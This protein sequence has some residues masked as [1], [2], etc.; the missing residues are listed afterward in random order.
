ME[1]SPARPACVAPKRPLDVVFKDGF[2]LSQDRNDLKDLALASLS[3]ALKAYF[4]SYH[5]A[6]MVRD[7]FQEGGGGANADSSYSPRYFEDCAE[8]ILHFH[9]F[10][11]LSLKEVLRSKHQLLAADASRLSV[12]LDKLLAN[13]AVSAEEMVRLSSP[14]F[15]DT[16]TR[17]CDLIRAGRLDQATLS[18]IPDAGELLKQLNNLRN[19]LWHRGTFIL[20]YQAFDELIGGSVLP[21]VKKLVSLQH[22]GH[23]WGYP[24]LHCG[25]D[26]AEEIIA[27]MAGGRRLRKVA[28]LKELGRA[29]FENPAPFE[30]GESWT[31]E[32]RRRAT[33]AAKSEADGEGVAEIRACPVCGVESLV[34]YESIEAEGEES[35][36]GEAELVVRSTFA[37]RCM[38][39]T[40]SI[41]TAVDNASVWGLRIDD[42]WRHEAY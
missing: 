14:E 20:R 25:I 8:T 2:S 23:G 16:L 36:G 17:L 37:V 5:S 26:P 29:A 9:H 35:P 33:A 7:L 28:Y 31:R 1:K 27:E 41:D 38:C 24:A 21:F 15:A 11:E 42:Y 34:V 18:F 32:E 6:Q 40:F 4:R 22:N 30:W 3:V 12:I 10:I 39:C 19:R 13:E